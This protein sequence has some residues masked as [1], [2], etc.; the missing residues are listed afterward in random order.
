MEKRYSMR[1]KIAIASS[2]LFIMTVALSCGP[3]KSDPKI[4]ASGCSIDHADKVKEN[5]YI[6]VLA[7]IVGKGKMVKILVNDNKYILRYNMET[8]FDGEAA[9]D[10]KGLKK[11]VMPLKKKKGFC[12]IADFKPSNDGIH[13]L[14]SL[15]VTQT[16]TMW[17]RKSIKGEL[18][19]GEFVNL[20]QNGL[21][22]N[23]ELI[24]VREPFEVAND[25]GIQVLGAK[26]IP[27]GEL[28]GKISELDKTKKYYIFCPGGERAEIARDIL[29]QNHI[30]PYFMYARIKG[31]GNGGIIIAER[32]Q[33][34]SY[35]LTASDIESIKSGKKASLGSKTSSS[36][37]SAG[38]AIGGTEGC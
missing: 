22:P 12:V 13:V 24:D 3:S 26:N 9:T 18:R 1:K 30:Y 15:E 10:K 36:G 8:K 35:T 32:D 28:P 2:V 20:A 6:G 33:S 27:L 37:A 38:A 23:A 5:R 25:P 29:A 7:G 11:K 17:S 4:I 34:A 21:A 16:K 14:K 19:G 31:D